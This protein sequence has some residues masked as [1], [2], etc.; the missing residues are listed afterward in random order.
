VKPTIDRL[1]PVGIWFG[2][3]IDTKHHTEDDPREDLWWIQ[4]CGPL[5]RSD[6][7]PE[8]ILRS[9]GGGRVESIERKGYYA[10]DQQEWNTHWAPQV[11]QISL[12]PPDE[13][14]RLQDKDRGQVYTRNRP[15]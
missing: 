11:M 9:A 4:Y 7:N 12:V 14:S 5:C 13:V 6:S 8:L 15:R 1:T 3:N 2:L 10:I